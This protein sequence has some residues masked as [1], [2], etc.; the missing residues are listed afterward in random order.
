M[1]YNLFFYN[2]FK[3]KCYKAQLIIS[4]V[5]LFSPFSICP[6]TGS[7]FLASFFPLIYSAAFERLFTS[8]CFCA[9]IRQCTITLSLYRC[10]P[11]CFFVLLNSNSSLSSAHSVYLHVLGHHSCTSSQ[12]LFAAREQQLPWAMNRTFLL[13]VRRLDGRQMRVEMRIRVCSSGVLGMFH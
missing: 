9:L 6:P 3:I 13:P 12:L 7:L 8:R 4:N 5:H 1:F 2:H 11:F 10:P